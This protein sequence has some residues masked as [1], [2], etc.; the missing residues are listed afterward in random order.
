MEK[1]FAMGISPSPVSGGAFSG[2]GVGDRNHSLSHWRKPV[3]TVS[4]ALSIRWIPAFAGMTVNNQNQKMR[5]FCLAGRTR[6]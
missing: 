1:Q 5:G 2:Y 6:P 3:S 4:A